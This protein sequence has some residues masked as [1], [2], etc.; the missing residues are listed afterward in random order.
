VH[1]TIVVVLRKSFNIRGR[2]AAQSAAGGEAVIEGLLTASAAEGIPPAPLMDAEAE[3]FLPRQPHR[4][5]VTKKRIALAIVLFLF[6]GLAGAYTQKDALSPTFANYSRRVIGDENTARVESWFFTVED[7]VDQVK[8]RVLG[9][10]TNPFATVVRVEAVPRTPGRSVIYFVSA[11]GKPTEAQLTAESLGPAPLQLPKTIALHDNL[12]AG[13]GVWSTVGL[14]HNTASDTLMAKT[15]VHPDKTRPYA[16]VG[17]LLMDS[18]RVRLHM[19]A[20]TVDPGGFRGAKGP[21]VMSQDALSSL[22]AAWNGGFK[23]PHGNFGMFA[24]GSEYVPMRN[25]LATI[26][27]LKDGQIKM[28]EWGADLV[29]D[30]TMTACR[31][32]VVLLIQN[33][34]VSKRTT[35]GND[36][37]GYVN[38]NSSEFITWRS[39]VGLTKDGNLIYA[40]GN[41]LSADSLA[42]AL[43]AEGAYTAMQLDI[44]N[45]YV[46]LGTFAPQADGSLKADKFMDTMSDSPRRFL[47]TQER[48]FMWVTLDE[49]RYH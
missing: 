7:H 11:N 17:A 38:V 2:A 28:G 24:D 45:P 43:W 42:R 35:E 29:R 37:W 25:G 6:V 21:G 16:T 19:T 18:R 13:E 12:E 47:G 27:V 33:G 22:L 10:R 44:N 32:N 8:Y 49:S 14:P 40:A 4:R 31:Q 34:E 1:V 5:R 9:G 30:D 23:G 26:C 20:G 3:P 15:F 41:S 39:A 36:T 46:L 48:D